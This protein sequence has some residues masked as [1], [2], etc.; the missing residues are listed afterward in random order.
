MS[1]DAKNRE[2]CTAGFFCRRFYVKMSGS[3]SV[4]IRLTGKWKMCIRDSPD[5]DADL[6]SWTVGGV[7]TQSDIH[8]TGL[9]AASGE[10]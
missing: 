5:S 10:Y 6:L 7:W 2:I 4:G 1:A 8:G 3:K 9:V